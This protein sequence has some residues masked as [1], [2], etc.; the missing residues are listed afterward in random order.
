[1][2][3][4]SPKHKRFIHDYLVN[5]AEPAFKLITWFNTSFMSEGIIFYELWI[6]EIQTHPC[7]LLFLAA[8]DHQDLGK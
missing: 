1:M 3:K 2:R 4:L 5:M 8:V 7:W 6:S